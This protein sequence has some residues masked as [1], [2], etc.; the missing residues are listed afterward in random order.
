MNEVGCELN[1]SDSR[2]KT[3]VIALAIAKIY[4]AEDG[5]FSLQYTIS[6]IDQ[7]FLKLKTYNVQ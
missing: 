2:R 7:R 1:D 5:L 6:L 4:N 3:H